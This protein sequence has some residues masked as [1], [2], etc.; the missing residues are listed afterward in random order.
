MR[1]EHVEAADIRQTLYNI[2]SSFDTYFLNMSYLQLN[3]SLWKLI[4]K[5]HSRHDAAEMFLKLVFPSIIL[6]TQYWL[7]YCLTPNEQYFSY[8]YDKIQPYT[9][10][11]MK[12]RKDR[13]FGQR[14]LTATEKSM[15]SCAGMIIL[16]S[17]SGYNASTLLRKI[18]CF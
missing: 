14:F 11:K 9:K 4:H 15:E 10:P 3:L 8:I 18:R 5:I 12:R 16:V 7:I 6:S 17:W 13:Q 2:N 1:K